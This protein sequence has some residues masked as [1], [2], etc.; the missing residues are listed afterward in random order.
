MGFGIR[1]RSVSQT[2]GSTFDWFIPDD[3][4]MPDQENPRGYLIGRDLIVTP[5]GNTY[6]YDKYRIKQ[7][8]LNFRDI[9]TLSKNS[10][11]HITSGWI[12]QKQIVIVFAGS[13][14]T[15]TTIAPGSLASVNQCWGTG[16][17]E[18]TSLPKE[19]VLD[20]WDCDFQLTQF[21]P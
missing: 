5:S 8:Q 13:S 1:L 4:S 9:P 17:A 7:W 19:T 15:G 20:L 2:L 18:F 21:G 16:Y 11:E 6:M 12:G 10:L 3:G 14:V